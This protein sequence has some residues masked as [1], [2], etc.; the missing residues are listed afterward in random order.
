MN[1]TPAT[2]S[3]QAAMLSVIGADSLDAFFD[4]IPEALRSC[5]WNLT[6]GLSEFSLRRELEALAAK[7]NTRYI[8]FLGGGY[9]DHY[10]P[11]AVDAL[12]SRSEFYTAYTPYQP[13]CS[14]GTLQAIY[15]YQS[16]VSLLMDL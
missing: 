9:Y 11:A 16:V 10:I 6:D 15:E 1:W 8:S 2:K 5:D 3:E 7:N 4:V 12:S 14:Q 13:E